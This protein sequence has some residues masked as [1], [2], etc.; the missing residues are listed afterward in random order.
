MV[1]FIRGYPPHTS[2][3]VHALSAVRSIDAA[4]FAGFLDFIRFEPRNH[5]KILR[6]NGTM[7]QQPPKE[8]TRLRLLHQTRRAAVTLT[9]GTMKMLQM[10]DSMSKAWTN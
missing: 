2:L 4:S 8:P 9:W 3:T 7:T 1:L 10:V 6:L 5:V